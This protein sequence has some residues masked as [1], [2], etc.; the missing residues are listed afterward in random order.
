MG[1]D[2]EDQSHEELALA[3]ICGLDEFDVVPKKYLAE[4]QES[5]HGCLNVNGECAIEILV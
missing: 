2:D 5:F 3:E 1:Y 4:F